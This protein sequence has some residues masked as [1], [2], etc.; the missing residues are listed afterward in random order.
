MEGFNEKGGQ[1][2]VDDLPISEIADKYNTPA[3][4]YS[5][6]EIRNNYNKYAKALR[7]GDLICYAVKANSNIHILKELVELGSGF[8]VVSGNELKRCIEAGADLN[9]IVFSGVAK[10]S[11]DLE[12]A[13]NAGIL[14][15]NIESEDE[16]DRIVNISK[17]LDKEVQCSIRINP[18]IPTGS[19][20]YIETGLKTSKF[21]VDTET[22]LNISAKAKGRPLIKVSGIACHIGSQISDNGLILKSLEHLLNAHKLLTNDGHEIHFLDVGG[23]LGITYKEENPGNPD[24]L[25]AEILNEIKALNLNIVLEPGRSITGTAGLLISKVEYLKLTEY[26]NFAIIDAG[27]NDLMRPALYDAWHTV[28]EIQKSNSEKRI[29]DLVGPVCESTDVLA[30]ERELTISQGDL[31][32]FMDAGAYGSVMSSNYNSRLKV[33]EVMVNGSSV[34]LIKKRESFEDSIAL[35]TDL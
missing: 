2:Y 14:S 3:F 8:D 35:E 13:I 5:G 26:K 21:G 1:L 9:K 25:I 18:D 17:T 27:M 23:G 30:K 15:I 31:I 4:I 29:Y 32:A 33:P 34:K 7:E 22:L 28:K 16:F 12:L 10:S 11:E 20:K 6:S 24:S 19:H